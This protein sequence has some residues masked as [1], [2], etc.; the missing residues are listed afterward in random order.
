M[1]KPVGNLL[2]DQLGTPSMGSDW[3]GDE[4]IFPL[5]KGGMDQVY[6]ALDTRLGRKD[7]LA[8]PPRMPDQ[9]YTIVLHHSHSQR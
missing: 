2:G 8:H 5:G 4:I 6:L 7:E 9:P 1:N 3:K